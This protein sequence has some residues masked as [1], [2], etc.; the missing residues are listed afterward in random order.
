MASI[1]IPVVQTDVTPAPASVT[2]VVSIGTPSVSTGGD[3]SATPN[4][5]AGV[6]AI[7][8]PTILVVTVALAGGVPATVAIGVPLISAGVIVSPGTVEAFVAVASPTI[9]AQIGPIPPGPYPPD[10]KYTL[11]STDINGADICEIPMSELSYSFVL[12]DSGTCS[13]KTPFHHA[14]TGTQDNGCL[15]I[16]RRDILVY[17]EGILVWGGR[18]WDYQANSGT[19]IVEFIAKDWFELM[20]MRMIAPEYKF[21]FD[22]LTDFFDVFWGVFDYANSQRMIGYSRGFGQ[23]GEEKGTETNRSWHEWQ[24]LADIAVDIANAAG[25]WFDFWVDADKTVQTRTRPGVEVGSPVFNSSNIASIR[26]QQQLSDVATQVFVQGF[27]EGEDSSWGEA[28]RS[29]D[30]K[31]YGKI[32]QV[33]HRPGTCNQHWLD[34][35]ADAFVRRHRRPALAMEIDIPQDKV[36]FDLPLGL[37]YPVLFQD[38]YLDI[39]AT[40]RLLARQVDWDKSGK[41]K[42]TLVMD[43]NLEYQVH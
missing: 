19:G 43:N 24:T 17:R 31:T 29:A 3:V 37:R 34:V 26:V 6:A 40:V 18:L 28:H 32:H 16:G 41:E 38:G 22:A 20:K 2:A 14:D 8:T 5:V 36:T 23:W 11:I 30:Y 12:D 27:G 7:G 33:W 15:V 1:G 4:V 25:F 9:L 42:A 39:D 21:H 10:P 35:Y 13:F